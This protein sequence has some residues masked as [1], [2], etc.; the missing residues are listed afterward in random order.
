MALARS[1]ASALSG[2]PLGALGVAA[3][4]ARGLS[5]SSAPAGSV[6]VGLGAAAARPSASSS[7]SSVPSSP[8]R[9]YVAEAAETSSSDEEFGSDLYFSPSSTAPRYVASAVPEEELASRLH[10]IRDWDDEVDGDTP[11]SLGVGTSASGASMSMAK[12]SPEDG[13]SAPFATFGDLPAGAYVPPSPCCPPSLF[14]AIMNRVPKFDLAVDAGV[15]CKHFREDLAGSFRRVISIGGAEPTPV[16]AGAPG[17]PTVDALHANVIRAT[18]RAE[19]L[20][21]VVAPGSVDFVSTVHAYHSMDR[22]RFLRAARR[23]LSPDGTLALVGSLRPRIADPVDL[24][25]QLEWF[26]SRAL[27]GHWGAGRDLAD[28]CYEGALPGPGDFGEVERLETVNAKVDWRVNDFLTYLSELPAY[29]SLRARDPKGVDPLAILSDYC[30]IRLGP[31][32]TLGIEV[33][34]YAV[35]ARKPV[36]M[37]HEDI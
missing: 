22:M 17:L 25:P 36:P 29:R 33:P 20:E 21:K 10:P 9:S 24:D 15:G 7:P 30:D 19:D 32:A 16:P 35:I 2:V 14:G 27:G 31:G 18:G 12:L 13:A 1:G 11:G 5:S 28:T 37:G 23:A 34:F 4:A 3:S 8:R 26:Y 6:A